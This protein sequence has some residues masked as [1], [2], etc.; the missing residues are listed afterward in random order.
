[1]GSLKPVITMSRWRDSSAVR[2]PNIFLVL[3]AL[4]VGDPVFVSTS[5]VSD[6]VVYPPK[7]RRNMRAICRT[8]T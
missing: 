2:M 5:D 8:R 3:A 6:I 7:W 1:M 4:L